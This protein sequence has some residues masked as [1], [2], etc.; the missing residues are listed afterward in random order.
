MTAGLDAIQALVLRI[1]RWRSKRTGLTRSSCAAASAV[2][3]RCAAA[4]A[5]AGSPLRLRRARPRDR[6]HA[7]R[8]QGLIGGPPLSEPFRSGPVVRALLL[9]H[10]GPD[11]RQPP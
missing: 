2:I 3:V 7:A 4:P 9:V 6:A 5:W 1:A 8:Q 11:R 10:A